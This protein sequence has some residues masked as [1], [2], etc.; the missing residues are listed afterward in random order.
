MATETKLLLQLSALQQ[1][2]SKLRYDSVKCKLAIDAARLAAWD[3]NVRTG[4]VIF[5][6]FYA[7]CLGY[8]KEELTPHVDT[9]G[10]LLHPDDQE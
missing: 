7:Q 2:N 9:W 3:Y 1:E 4:V 8:E 10:R 6:D 5:N